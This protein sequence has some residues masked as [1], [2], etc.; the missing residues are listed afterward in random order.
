MGFPIGWLFVVGGVYSSFSMSATFFYYWKKS[1]F[2]LKWGCLLALIEARL[3]NL[4]LPPI[5]SFIVV[6]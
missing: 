5:L 3:L 4:S 2:L 1:A 6:S